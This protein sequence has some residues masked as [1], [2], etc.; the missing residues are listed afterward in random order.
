MLQRF[1][2]IT[3]RDRSDDGERFGCRGRRRNGCDIGGGNR[4]GR[5]ACGYVGD[6]FIDFVGE[7]R[8][9]CPHALRE[10]LRRPALD[11]SPCLGDIVLDPPPEIFA[12]RTLAQEHLAK[13]PL[14]GEELGQLGRAVPAF[15]FQHQRARRSGGFEIAFEGVAIRRDKR[16]GVAH[17]H[18]AMRREKRQGAKFIQHLHQSRV[19]LEGA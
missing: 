14:A 16:I 17:H 15:H 13:V 9:V 8:E 10:H 11:R 7:H 18:H 2:G 5:R 4:P 6:E 3:H 12:F 19:T 1:G